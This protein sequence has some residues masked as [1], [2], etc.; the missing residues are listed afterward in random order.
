MID[1]I[2][3]IWS[4]LEGVIFIV[5]LSSALYLFFKDPIRRWSLFG[6][7]PTC[8]LVIFDPKSKKVVLVKRKI[9]NDKWQFSQGGIYGGDIMS[10]VESIAERELNLRKEFYRVLY[11]KVLKVLNTENHI[12]SD[13]SYIFGYFS[14]FK[15]FKG[16]GYLACFIEMDLEKY[17]EKIKLG[18]GMQKLKITK[19]EDA[20]IILNKEKEKDPEKIDLLLQILEEVKDDI[21][22]IKEIEDID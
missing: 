10:Y 9:Q 14:L 20:E 21:V 2:P 1:L 12:K 6:Y 8:I 19:I 22:N 18:Y 4:Y 7:R 13:Q 3:H 15:K 11:L 5:S 17:E 16:K